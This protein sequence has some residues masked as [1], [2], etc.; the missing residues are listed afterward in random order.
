GSS[1]A[2]PA[3]NCVTNGTAGAGLTVDSCLSVAVRERLRAEYSARIADGSILQLHGGFDPRHY[4]GEVIASVM[5]VAQDSDDAALMLWSQQRLADIHAAL[6]AHNGYHMWPDAVD[7]QPTFG[8]L[9]QARLVLSLALIYGATG[10]VHAREGAVL[11]F[12]ALDHMPR[13]PVTSSITGARYELPAYAYHDIANPVAISGRTLDP[14]HDAVLAAAYGVMSSRVLTDPS[15]IAGARDRGAHYLAA[16]TDMAF[17]G[18]CLPLADMPEYINACDTRYNGFWAFMLEIA[19]RAMPQGNAIR[20][21]D[22]QARF[23]GPP[24]E[25]FQT[26][27]TYPQNY[28]GAYPDPVEPLTLMGSVRRTMTSA[29]ATLFVD[30]A[31]ALMATQDMANWPRGNLYPKFYQR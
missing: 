20:A 23:A 31:N 13:L 25:A 7:G 19:A 15:Q 1:G 2:T 28:A 5:A 18:R 17:A 27:R 24:A 14:N 11:A 29:N 9:A 30:R 3:G 26:S 10:D 16:A 21:I 8:E 12:S 4:P 6:A 22:E